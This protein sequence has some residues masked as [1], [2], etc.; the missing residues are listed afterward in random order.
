[1]ATSS[2]RSARSTPARSKGKGKSNVT[3]WLWMAFAL[4]VETQAAI[5]RRDARTIAV[6]QLEADLGLQIADQA[7]HRRLPHPKLARGARHRAA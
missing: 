1:M 7:G 3:P 2:T 6:K 5:R 4:L